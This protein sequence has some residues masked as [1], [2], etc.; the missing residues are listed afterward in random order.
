MIKCKGIEKKYGE[1]TILHGVDV[2]VA[3]NQ[4]TV[5]IGQSGSGKTTLLKTLSLIEN[6]D[7]GIVTI[8]NEE[9]HF[10]NVKQKI[11]KQFR[12][13]TQQTVGVVFQNLDLIPH[14]TNK[15]NILKPLG[16]SISIGDEKELEYL[17]G[18]FKM[19]D[20]IDKMPY[21]CSRGEQQRVA[22]VRA[23][24][25]KPKYLFLDEITSALD[26]ELIAILFKYLIELK[27][28]GVGIFIITHFLLFAQ[29][30][31]DKI[32]FISQG[33]IVEQGSK[34]IMISPS[35]KKLQ[36][37]LLSLGGIILQ[38]VNPKVEDVSK[39]VLG[40]NKNLLLEFEESTDI[41]KKIR[42]IYRILDYE[43]LDK[44]VVSDVY[45]F[46]MDHFSDFQKDL[47]H[48][49]GIKNDDANYWDVLDSYIKERLSNEKYPIHKNWIYL[50]SYQTISNW[51]K[52][53]LKPVLKEYLAPEYPINFKVANEMLKELI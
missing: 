38:N 30:L 44:N 39:G 1:A 46:I 42:L 5:L 40:I 13:N 41:N 20:F 53:D 31:A 35:T 3:S 11:R 34:D 10:P 6:P 45:Y 23:V 49:L 7:N 22:F 27:N 15:K 43:S 24:M 21:Q 52:H 4:I 36:D 26:P 8:E 18:I 29:N 37:F 16:K 25:L 51:N 33:K 50:L 14:W 2:E 28:K 48:W 9:F 19:K 17:L 32:I 12:L 47:E